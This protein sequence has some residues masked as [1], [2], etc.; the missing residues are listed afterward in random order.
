MLG[1]WYYWHVDRRI[2]PSSNNRR[3]QNGRW[4]ERPEVII[5]R[6]VN[7]GSQHKLYPTLAHD[8]AIWNP[9]MDEAQIL[10]KL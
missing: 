10:N 8:A 3:V 2:K 4:N 5:A 9:C 1:Y 6:V 7:E